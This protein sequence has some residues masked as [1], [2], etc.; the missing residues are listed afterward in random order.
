MVHSFVIL[1]QT[2]SIHIHIAYNNETFHMLWNTKVWLNSLNPW[3][4]WLTLILTSL[5]LQMKMVMK[6][7]IFHEFINKY[8]FTVFIC[9]S[10]KVR[11]NSYGEAGKVDEFRSQIL[12]HLVL[13]LD[14]NVLWL[15]KMNHHQSYIHKHL[16]IKLI[17][18]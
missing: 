9:N 7:S 13:T 16:W 5:L 15:Q 17:C 12:Q 4:M 8:H 6:S 1:K 14:L 18:C 10:P 11:L 2:F 3:Q